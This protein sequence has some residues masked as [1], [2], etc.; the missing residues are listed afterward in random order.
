[1]KKDRYLIYINW[2][3]FGKHYYDLANAHPYRGTPNINRLIKE[4]VCFENLYTGI[5]SITYPMQSAIVSGAYSESTENVYKYYS[6]EEE[7]LVLCRRKNSSETIG[8]VLGKEN[9]PFVSIQQFAL[10]D[11]GAQWDDKDFL[12]VQPGGDYKLRFNELFKLLDGEEIFSKEK[13]FKYEEL[14]KVL[15]L[16]VDD[17]DSIGHNQL[18]KRGKIKALTESGRIKN[19][20][21]RLIEMDKILGQLIT[22]LENLNIY[23]NTTILL[24]TDHGMVPFKGK[25]CFN[26][27]KKA[28]EDLN[29]TNIKNIEKEGQK[30]DFN[31]NDVIAVSTGV[32]LQLYFNNPSK[33]TLETIK[34]RLQKEE[35]IDTCLTK[36]ELIER[37]TASFFADILVSP[38]LPHHFHLNEDKYYLLGGAHD[39][40]NEKAQNIFGVLKGNAF[41]SSYSLSK[42]VYNIDFIPTLCAALDIP[43]PENNKGKIIESIFLS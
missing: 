40:L 13:S 8:Q 31:H 21:S 42:R 25:S 7:K 22:K 4:G 28:L 10:L 6:R 1:M 30:A 3:G 37:G 5:P 35:Y 38:K 36:Y 12:Y 16:Y 19:V 11:K 20:I 41:K 14:P 32:Q 43:L 33:K 24:T 17:L 34:E 26:K 15:F 29:F 27:L 23:D 18:Y 2:D 9:I 39:S